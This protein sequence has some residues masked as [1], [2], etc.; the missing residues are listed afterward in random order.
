MLHIHKRLHQCRLLEKRIYTR[1]FL[2]SDANH[3]ALQGFTT[4]DHIFCSLIYK[5]HSCDLAF[6]G[7]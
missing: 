4:Y 6:E 5:L 7:A 1:Y 3:F 2:G